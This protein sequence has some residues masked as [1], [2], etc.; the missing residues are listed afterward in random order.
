MGLCRAVPQAKWTATRKFFL[1]IEGVFDSIQSYYRDSLSFRS[2][3]GILRKDIDRYTDIMADAL[4]EVPETAIVYAQETYDLL[5]ERL[6]SPS[7]A[8]V[9]GYLDRKLTIGAL[10]ASAGRTSFCG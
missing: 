5:R 10:A 8:I 1:R 7:E 6:R 9:S 2:D 4:G 3:P